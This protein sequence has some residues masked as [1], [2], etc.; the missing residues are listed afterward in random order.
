MSDPT[1]DVRLVVEP[2]MVRLLP[3]T[4]RA[5]GFEVEGYTGHDAGSGM[6]SVRLTGRM[7][8]RNNLGGLVECLR[9]NHVEVAPDDLHIGGGEAPWAS[10]S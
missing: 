8:S 2:T 9:Y 5:H 10:A 7:R 4:F 3:P 1:F 6:R